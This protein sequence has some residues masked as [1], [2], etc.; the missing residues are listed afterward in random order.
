MSDNTLRI[1]HVEDDQVDQLVVK[2]FLGKLSRVSAIYHAYNGVEALDKLR[3]ENGQTRLDPMPN[4]ILADINMPMINGIEF[5]HELRQ[6]PN[7]KHLMVYILTTSNDAHDIV[8][9]YQEQV[10]GYIIKPVDL[11]EFERTVKVLEDFWKIC[12]FPS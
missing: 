2:R 7:L 5:V 6:D 10:A 4:I 9:A 8:N 3:G 1:L 11:N 12:V